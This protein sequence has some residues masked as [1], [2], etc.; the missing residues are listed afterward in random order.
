M[1]VDLEKKAVIATS[2]PGKMLEEERKHI[3]YIKRKEEKLK[4]VCSAVKTVFLK[5]NNSLS[6]AA[7]PSVL[8]SAGGEQDQKYI[9]C[10][11][12]GFYP[13]VIRVRWTQKGRPVYF[14]VSSTGILPHRDGTFQMTSYLSLVNMNAD[15]V[16]CEIE[17]LSLDGILKKTYEEKSQITE[18]VLWAT[19]AFSLG[20]ALPVFLTV[21]FIRIKKQ[22]TEPPEDTSDGSKASLSL[23]LMNVSQ[24]T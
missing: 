9:K 2:E 5:S 12:H 8:L 1:H 20:F 18:Y 6:R 22:T 13:N 10:V 21:I 23:N 17:H 14:G 16:T 4:M 19:V 3:E 11:V 15:G 24:E 7:K